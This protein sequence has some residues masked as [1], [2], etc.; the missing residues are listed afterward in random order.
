MGHSDIK[1]DGC[2]VNAQTDATQLCRKTKPFIT[3]MTT[4]Q[5]LRTQTQSSVSADHVCSSSRT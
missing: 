4:V 5:T 3:V 2:S 1:T